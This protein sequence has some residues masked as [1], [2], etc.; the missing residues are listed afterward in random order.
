MRFH[1]FFFFLFIS[2]TQK[3]CISKYCWLRTQ[4]S[5]LASENNGYSVNFHSEPE[6]PELVHCRVIPEQFCLHLPKT[7]NACVMYFYGSPLPELRNNV[8]TDRCYITQPL[9]P[10]L[11]G[12]LFWISNCRFH[13]LYR[14]PPLSVS[15]ELSLSL[16]LSLSEGSAVLPNWWRRPTFP[17]PLYCSTVLRNYGRH[18]AKTME[19]QMSHIHGPKQLCILSPCWRK[20]CP[21][22]RDIAHRRSHYALLFNSV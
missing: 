1:C 19:N 18:R 22:W 10:V 3:A 11:V 13:C 6:Q 7:H 2:N 8:H 9:F 17:N 5:S 16:S 20:T 4:N 15:L 14:F 12:A 21:R